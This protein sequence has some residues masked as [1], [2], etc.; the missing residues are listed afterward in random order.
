M[1]DL[2]ID[3]KA[4]P[5]VRRV[6]HLEEFEGPILT[7][8]R[9]EGGTVYVEKWCSFHEG[10]VRSVIVRSDQRSIAE[11]LAKRMTMMELLT[12]PNDDIGFLLDR[13]G[14]QA[15]LVQLVQ[16]SN[17]PASYLPKASAVHDE[18]L[19]PEW[20]T[21]PQTFLVD[22]N[23]NP[24]LLYELERDYLT[25]F[26]FNYFLDPTI[27]RTVPY[28]ALTYVLDGGFSYASL[29]R[30]FR[31][32]VPKNDN[33]RAVAAIAASPGVLVISAPTHGADRLAAAMQ[34]AAA[35]ETTK[36]YHA[37][38]AWSKLTEKK[39]DG[40]PSLEAAKQQYGRL[41]ALLL[42][43]ASRLVPA[44]PEPK[45]LLRAGKV[46]AAY[47]RLLWKLIEPPAEG[48]EFLSAGI[49][50]ESD[51]PDSVAEDEEPEEEEFDED[52]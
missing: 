8:L 47:Y 51:A 31:H 24:K 12:R 52:E 36:A 10:A 26:A 7:E 2:G 11:Y 20:E 22:T 50:K 3:F 15:R 27:N 23:W 17:L 13:V 38:H 35:V 25:T 32:S 18:S 39:I 45:Q 34:A 4:F 41:A 6:R 29:F 30:S 42:I 33:A 37:L 28:P 43:D 5:H 49:E 46:L 21:T 44:N 14:K 19:R 1:G 16:V 9:G 40:M 48:V